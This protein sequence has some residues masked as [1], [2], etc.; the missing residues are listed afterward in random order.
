MKLLTESSSTALTPNS[1]TADLTGHNSLAAL[2]REHFI[3]QVIV[4]GFGKARPEECWKW[5]WCSN[6]GVSDKSSYLRRV[7]APVDESLPSLGMT[8][9]DEALVCFC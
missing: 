1:P 2:P 3:W 8:A 6:K 7:G 5:N 4:V 9:A